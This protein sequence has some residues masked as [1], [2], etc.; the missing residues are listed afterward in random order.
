MP[1]I[2]QDIVNIR[3]ALMLMHP[4]DRI[5]AE[6][7]ARYGAACALV[8]DRLRQSADLLRKGLR[9]EAL[10]QAMIDPPVLDLFAQ[11]DFPERESWLRY[12][13]EQG[14]TQP[15]PLQDSLAVE[16][17][18]AFAEADNLKEALR[19]HRTLA[20]ARAPL[21]RRLGVLWRLAK[22]DPLNAIW[23]KDVREF[24][25]ARL[26][27]L[28]DE[29]RLAAQR[30]DLPHL[31]RLAQELAV[32]DWSEPPPS[33]LLQRVRASR[34]R[35]LAQGARERLV[36]LEAYLSVAVAEGDRG[37]AKAL[38]DQAAPLLGQVSF[39]P[40][41]PLLQRLELAMHWV[42]ERDARDQR[43]RQWEQACEFLE[44]TLDGRADPPTLATLAE[45]EETTLAYGMGMP[46]GLE[47]AL[48]S[49][50][51]RLRWRGRF[52]KTL[53]TFFFIALL[54]GGGYLGW[55]GL[56]APAK[57][58][59]DKESKV[60]PKVLAQEVRQIFQQRCDGCH[61]QKKQL[62]FGDKENFSYDLLTTTKA[63]RPE[64][65]YLIV[66]KR[67]EVSAIWARVLDGTMPR[68]PDP[69]LP[70]VEKEKIRA[71]I[72]TGPVFPD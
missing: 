38:H 19:R 65:K 29:V 34:D 56:F 6:T 53:W 48:A 20:L 12:C 31:E 35:F 21:Q 8:N 3:S 17:N 44:Q 23:L 36:Q 18:Q 46:K 54:A 26:R 14:L 1:D 51:S 47:R 64:G 33:A 72:L 15:P 39:A 13:Q 30:N 5:L 42:R 59:Q 9:T 70:A 66:A 27:E 41:D 63:D 25:K 61:R 52:K 50:K 40:G 68:K 62:S 16:L 37:K 49:K 10:Q 24:E 2:E 57:S 28:D 67:P 43:Q 7:A 11:V 32:P 71:W 58:D 45:L 4:A 55:R 60:D 69:P 22:L